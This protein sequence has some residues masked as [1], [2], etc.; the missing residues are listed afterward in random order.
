LGLPIAK[1]I[2]EVHQGS[3]SVRSTPGAGSSFTVRLPLLS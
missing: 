3:I 2:A 1:W